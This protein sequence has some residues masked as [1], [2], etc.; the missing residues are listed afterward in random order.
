MMLHTSDA[1][2]QG[3]KMIVLRTVDSDVVVLAVAE[4]PRLRNTQPLELASSL[5][6][7]R[8]MKWQHHLVLVNLWRYLV[9][10]VEV[11]VVV[12]VI[13][14]NHCFTSLFGTNQRRRNRSGWYGLSRTNIL[15]N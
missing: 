3:L 11:V 8:L 10:V 1:V 13:V 2:Q 12:V 4:F 5:G 15:P 14:V 7:Y 9:V 6:K